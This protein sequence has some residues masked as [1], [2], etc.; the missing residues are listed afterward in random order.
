MLNIITA[1][2]TAGSRLIS[3]RYIT[4]TLPRM[5][6]LSHYFSL[7]I[8]FYPVSLHSALNLTSFISNEMRPPPPPRLRLSQRSIQASIFRERVRKASHQV[9]ADG[10]YMLKSLINL[11]QVSDW[12]WGETWSRGVA[13]GAETWTLSGTC[14]MWEVWR[15]VWQTYGASLKMARWWLEAVSWWQGAGGV[16]WSRWYAAGPTHHF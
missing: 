6:V 15:P 9:K 2:R 12:I 10:S 8:F 13:V 4:S 11:T 7:I 3:V 5:S 1:R 16:W 14:W